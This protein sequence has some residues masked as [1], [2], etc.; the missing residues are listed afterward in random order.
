MKERELETVEDLEKIAN[1]TN[2]FN[3]FKDTKTESTLSRA[4]PKCYT[5][6]NFDNIKFNSLNEQTLF[7]IFYAI[8]N[9]QIQIDAFN[10]L[11]NRDFY[12]SKTLEMFC[13]LK[14]PQ[15]DYSNKSIEVFNPIKWEKETKTI[16]FDSKFIDNLTNEKYK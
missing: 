11:I 9:S 8:P 12:Y 14:N 4:L 10:E 5:E 3:Y 15:A 2:S 13:Y 7:Y 1:R 6:F 16:L